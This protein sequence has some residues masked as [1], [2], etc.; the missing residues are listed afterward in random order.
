MAMLKYQRVIGRI[1]WNMTFWVCLE[2]WYSRQM[3]IFSYRKIGW[4][5]RGLHRVSCVATHIQRKLADPTPAIQWCEWG[6]I[7]WPRSYE[8]WVSQTPNNKTR[9]CP[10]HSFKENLVGGDWNMSCIFPFILGMA[11]ST[12]Q[13]TG[14]TYPPVICY[15]TNWKDPPCYSWD[16]SETCDWAIFQLANS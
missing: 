10:F 1:S 9:L 2:M 11:W 4:F 16:K 8:F 12:F 5:P 13:A 7:G 15:R 3:V 6:G 14:G